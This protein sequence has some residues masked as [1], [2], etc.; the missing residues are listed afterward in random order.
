MPRG[1][2]KMPSQ[3]SW[4]AELC[5][6]LALKFDPSAGDGLE[7]VEGSRAGTREDTADLTRYIATGRAR[8]L[9]RQHG[10]V[11]S[12]CCGANRIGA[13]CCG[14]VNQLLRQDSQRTCPHGD[15]LRITSK[16]SIIRMARM[17]LIEITN[18]KGFQSSS[19]QIWHCKIFCKDC[20]VDC[21]F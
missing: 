9:A 20:N 3:G 17:L 16:W 4:G 21:C 8:I 5:A 2:G 13:P 18:K 7:N 1:A 14:E 15:S 12:R 10:Q 6:F 19:K 11:F